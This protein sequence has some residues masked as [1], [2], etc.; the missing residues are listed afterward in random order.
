MATPWGS[1]STVAP[2]MMITNPAAA[3]GVR[4]GLIRRSPGRMRP[5]A[6]STSQTPMKWMNQGA[7]RAAGISLVICSTGIKNFDTPANRNN[8]ASKI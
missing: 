2:I 6:P 7:A 5:S 1:V 8:S 3:R 4:P